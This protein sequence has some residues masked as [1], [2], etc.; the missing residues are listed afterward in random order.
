M[1]SVIDHIIVFAAGAS[2]LVIEL[3][4]ARMLAPVFGTGIFV[5]ASL[6][7]VVLAALS[8]GYLVGGV[9]GSKGLSP[10]LAST[11]LESS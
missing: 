7:T 5:W 3:V 6:L 11:K 2:I 4:G 9:S 10:C 8:L 1:K